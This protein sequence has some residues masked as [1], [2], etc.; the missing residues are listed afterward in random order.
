MSILGGSKLLSYQWYRCFYWFTEKFTIPGLAIHHAIRKRII[1]DLYKEFTDEGC[2]QLIIIGG[3]FD[4]LSLM[5]CE[6]SHYHEL[7]ELDRA[8]TQLAKINALNLL[9]V[10]KTNIQFCSFDLIK[11]SVSST[12]GHTAPQKEKQTI[13]VCEGVLMYLTEK[14]VRNFLLDVSS[15][16]KSFYLIFTFMHNYSGSFHFRGTTLV[17]KSWLN[18]IGEPFMWGIQ[19]DQLERLL[20][21]CNMKLLHQ[22]DS[23][24]WAR[25]HLFEIK[26][27]I[28]E[29]EYI[30]VAVPA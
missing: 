20:R 9:G 18:L 15:N 12:C 7:I 5:A 16:Y 6:H 21:S 28:A 8:E 10:D 3:G 14:Q 23:T 26:P 29:G 27:L 30:A 25:K 19:A 11:D 24:K 17:A 4:L 2:C 1:W 13:I 22:T